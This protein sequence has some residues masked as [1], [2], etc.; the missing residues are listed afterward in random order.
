MMKQFTDRWFEL[1]ELMAIVGSS[2]K[3]NII[4]C[5]AENLSAVTRVYHE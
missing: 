5:N 3:K 4:N 2:F 1:D